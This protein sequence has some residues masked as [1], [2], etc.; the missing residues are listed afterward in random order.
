MPRKLSKGKDDAEAHGKDVEVECQSLCFCG[1]CGVI[2]GRSC[3]VNCG[4]PSNLNFWRRWYSVIVSSFP[5]LCVYHD[6]LRPEGKIAKLWISV[7]IEIGSHSECVVLFEYTSTNSRRLEGVLKHQVCLSS[8]TTCF[9]C[10]MR[11]YAAE[12]VL[13]RKPAYFIL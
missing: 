13:N 5:S 12:V 8:I 6:L 3:L 9:W 1:V 7:N 11:K 4:T 10:R 2:P